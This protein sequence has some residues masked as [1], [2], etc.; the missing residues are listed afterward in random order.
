M[1][2]G[3]DDDDEEDA[4]ER[5]KLAQCAR[6]SAEA[7]QSEKEKPTYR[8]REGS[9]SREWCERRLRSLLE[10]SICYDDDSSAGA[11]VAKP[12]SGPSV[13]EK[14]D[15]RMS[16]VRLLS[17]SLQPLAADHDRNGGR[18]PRD[19]TEAAADGDGGS[20]SGEEESVERMEALRSVT[21]AAQM[22]LGMRPTLPP[23]GGANCQYD[24]AEPKSVDLR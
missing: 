5:E 9:E 10:S 15:Q 14:A 22:D 19:R 24:A 3:S 8:G 4:A 13:G 16:C 23:Q 21:D 18:P 12:S 6:E 17:T 20:S 11:E 1:S 7:I 2:S